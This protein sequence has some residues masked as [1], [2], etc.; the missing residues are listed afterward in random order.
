[1]DLSL[2]RANAVY[3]YLW[4]KGLENQE[5]VRAVGYGEFQPRVDNSSKANKKL[6]RRVEVIV[7]AN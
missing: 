3:S 2:A 5:R 7:F 6:N 1:M 4:K